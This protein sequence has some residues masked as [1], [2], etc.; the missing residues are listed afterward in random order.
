LSVEVKAAVYDR[1]VN[2][3]AAT[4]IVAS[5]AA[6]ILTWLRFDSISDMARYPERLKLPDAP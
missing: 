4:R 2:T 1:Y 6:A 3:V 5:T